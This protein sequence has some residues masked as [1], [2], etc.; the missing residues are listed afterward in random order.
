MSKGL[1]ALR[2]SSVSWISALLPFCEDLLSLYL[3]LFMGRG[4][5]ERSIFW[6]GLGSLWE[7]LG[8]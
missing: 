2:V 1:L 4:V 8:W 5:I 6:F 7:L 3:G